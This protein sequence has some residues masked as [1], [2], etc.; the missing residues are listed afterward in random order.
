MLIMVTPTSSPMTIT[1]VADIIMIRVRKSGYL[2]KMK[3]TGKEEG[4]RKKENKKEMGWAI[5]HG[6]V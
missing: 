3:G 4:K 2:N 5:G 1:A 6:A